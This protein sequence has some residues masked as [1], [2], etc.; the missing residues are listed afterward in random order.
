MDSYDILH[1]WG[2]NQESNIKNQQAT[3]N[4]IP[5]RPC[6]AQLKEGKTNQSPNKSASGSLR[7]KTSFIHVNWMT[8]YGYM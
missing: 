7:S 2:R 8:N 4:K 1:G 5:E 6:S 3:V